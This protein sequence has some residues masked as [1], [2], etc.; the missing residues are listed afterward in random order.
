[1]I[2]AD[3]R[4]YGE[5][6]LQTITLET[7]ETG[8]HIDV[9]VICDSGRDQSKRA[10]H[11]I[12]L[13]GERAKKIAREAVIGQHV[14][15]VGHESNFNWTCSEC[16][17]KDQ[18]RRIDSSDLIEFTMHPLDFANPQGPVDVDNYNGKHKFRWLAGD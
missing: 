13:V 18:K 16:D 5:A 10:T 3:G 11:V 9:T 4:L 8:H 6:S 2:F 17:A 14:T 15:F 12:R 7:G 1:M